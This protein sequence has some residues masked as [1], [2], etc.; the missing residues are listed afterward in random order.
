MC[1]SGAGTESV[2]YKE[3][4]GGVCED[5]ADAV[6]GAWEGKDDQEGGK[7]GVGQWRDC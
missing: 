3:L 1:C 2:F 6:C 5:D 7:E 4:E